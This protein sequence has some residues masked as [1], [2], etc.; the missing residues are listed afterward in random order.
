MAASH[1]S[2][3]GRRAKIN[4]FAA[5]CDAAFLDAKGIPAVIYG[6]GDLLVAH[7]FNEYVETSELV[8]SAKSIALTLLDWCGYEES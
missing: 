7:A 1:M 6:P 2:A 4:G 5:V 8:D 3:T